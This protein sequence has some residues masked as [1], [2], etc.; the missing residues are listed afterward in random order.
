[1]EFLNDLK[2]QASWV[3]LEYVNPATRDVTNAPYPE[4]SK[5]IVRSGR[6]TPHYVGY[7]DKG[8]SSLIDPSFFTDNPNLVTPRVVLMCKK[9]KTKYLISEETRWKL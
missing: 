7:T 9:K 2:F 6:P 1:M 8:I 5:S 4:S 3:S